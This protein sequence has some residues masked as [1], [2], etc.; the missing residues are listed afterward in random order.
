MKNITELLAA[1]GVEI[2][3]DK[4]QAFETAFAENYKTVAEVDKLRSSRD[5]Y[6]SQL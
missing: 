5:N 1:A 2:P 6:K 3:E 4:K